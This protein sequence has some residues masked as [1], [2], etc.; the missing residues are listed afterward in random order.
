MWYTYS[1]VRSKEAIRMNAQLIYDKPCSCGVENVIR[2]A[3]QLIDVSWKP[4]MECA[5]N[6]RKYVYPTRSGKAH[7]EMESYTGMPYSS[8][9][10]LDHFVGLDVTLDTFMTAAQN[11]ASILYTRDL[12]DFEDAAF[13]CTIRNTFLA[14][15]VVCSAFVNY[16]LNLPLHRSTHEWDISPEFTEITERCA[17]A[18]QLCD[19]LVTTRPDGRTGGHVRIVTGI[20]RDADGRV[21]QVEI[22]E[23]VMPFPICKWYPAEEFNATLLGCGGTY[24]IYRYHH[25]DSVEYAPARYE[26]GDVSNPDLM[27]DH[28]DFSNYREGDAVEFNVLSDADELMLDDGAQIRSVRVQDIPMT[29]LWSRPFRIYRAEGLQPG[30]YTA[31]CVRNGER[32][33]PVHFRVVRTPEVLLTDEAGKAFPRIA[34]RPVAPD[35]SPLTQD[36][37]CFYREGKLNDEIVTFALTDGKRLIPTRAAVREIDGQLV[38]RTAA[39]LTD[40][41][42]KTVRSFVVG[43]DVTLYA[44]SAPEKAKVRA[45]FE[46]A[47]C[48]TPSYLSWKEEAAIS[49]EQRMLTPCEAAE[50]ATETVA[51]AHDNAYAHFMIF[52]S[53][54]YGRISTRP[55]LFVI[56]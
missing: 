49:Y 45:R 12:S 32:T 41:E 1:M 53:N 9:R 33:L 43:S 23:S 56:G 17:D 11:P 5:I 7:A 20:G 55:I 46:G 8:S 29:E 26:L 28:G 39:M 10:I 24:K 54:E 6:D 15:G 25:L 21:Q 34:L 18:L 31:W 44:L 52:C 2:R 3:H 16:S 50:A 38:A 51:Y 42:G 30:E 27:L 48:C 4:V 22:S 37:E 13:N 14:Y 19:T 36:S 40:A 47:A 35:G